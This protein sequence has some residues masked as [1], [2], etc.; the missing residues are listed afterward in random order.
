MPPPLKP[1]FCKPTTGGKNDMQSGKY[2]SLCH[3]VTPPLK[4]PGYAPVVTFCIKNCYKSCQKLL[5][6]CVNVTLQQKLS[7]YFAL[8]VPFY[9][10]TGSLIMNDIILLTGLFVLKNYL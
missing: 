4:N 10:M 6:F 2:P 9:D 5:C 8:V 3:N 7:N 1:S